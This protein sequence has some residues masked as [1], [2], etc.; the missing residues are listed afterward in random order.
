MTYEINIRY[1][2][3]LQLLLHNYKC[4]IPLDEIIMRQC[5]G[6]PNRF[7]PSFVVLKH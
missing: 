1:E 6:S 7:V 2:E 5:D 3:G 4:V